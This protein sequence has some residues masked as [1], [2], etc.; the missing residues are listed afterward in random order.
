M[1][2]SLQSLSKEELIERLVRLEAKL[3]L[4]PDKELKNVELAPTIFKPVTNGVSAMLRDD[5]TQHSPLQTKKDPR[6]PIFHRHPTR[7][8]ALLFTYQ[9][10]HYSGLALQNMPTPLP[11]V[12][13]ELLAALEK[14]H[15]IEKGAGQ[16]GCGFSRCGRTDR[17]VSS[18]G[19][20]I[21]LWVRSKRKPDDGGVELGDDWRPAREPIV[22]EPIESVEDPA[23]TNDV[24]ALAAKVDEVEIA[25]A[26]TAPKRA[27]R[28][29]PAL[30]SKM[31]P[32]EYNYP[33][34]LNRVLPPEIRVIGWS[35]LSTHTEFDARFSC[36]TRHYRY[37]FNRTPIPGQ[38]PLNMVKMQEAA[39]RL[40]GEHDFRNFCKVD[41]SKQI[42]NHCRRVHSA[43]LRRDVLGET[44]IIGGTKPVNQQKELTS[45]NNNAGQHEDWVFELIGSAFLW[46]QVRHIMA[47]L[48][49][50][51][52]E[53]EEPS[54]V[55]KLL[56]TGYEPPLY[57][58]AT[59][60]TVL[61]QIPLDPIRTEED[62]VTEI[63]LRKPLYSMASG[64]PLQLYR[65]LYK[66]GDVDWRH[67]SYDGPVASR[68]G[69][70]AKIPLSDAELAAATESTGNLLQIMKNQLEEAK[71]QTR[72]IQAFY[73][74]AVE[75]IHPH[76]IPIA[77]RAA[78]QAYT[79]GA[80]DLMASKK[81]VGLMVRPRSD[82]V[83][84]INRKWREGGGEK[85]RARVAAMNGVVGPDGE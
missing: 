9:G 26:T 67:G 7:K 84:E 8:I 22:P 38:R 61:V 33:Q 29:R 52:H 46:H 66:E 27:R 41:G 12:E 13:G 20:V 37:F 74:E 18:A 79:L 5:N 44:D 51:G 23:D 73:D 1:S 43:V 21:S 40:L 59:D 25:P 16:E 70:A 30:A 72:H 65:C 58:S 69:L 17:G 31:Q 83:E 2:Q 82:P 47:I 6:L 80:G 81:Y 19:Q 48:F 64:L 4:S 50:V 55:S 85:R 78:A 11:T 45:E 24:D 42:E 76:G 10:W 62:G 68:R 71:I 35:P 53:L 34:M 77:D 49:L 39:D 3:G 75:R 32:Y 63:L 28:S 57:P 36:Q 14:T 54:I 60:K 15:L 56:N